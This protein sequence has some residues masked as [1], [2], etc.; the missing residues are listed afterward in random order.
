[1]QAQGKGKDLERQQRQTAITQEL[2]RQLQQWEASSSSRRAEA[3]NVRPRYD[4]GP[5][6]VLKRRSRS[7]SSTKDPF[8]QYDAR[9]LLAT[10]A[11][12]AAQVQ[13]AVNEPAAGSKQEQRGEAATAEATAE[14]QSK[15]APGE[16]E[17]R[18]EDT[19]EEQAAATA[20][21]QHE[22]A[23]AAMF[24]AAFGAPYV[25]L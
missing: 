22:A 17:Q 14:E 6:F 1:M 5:R 2:D 24:Q 3:A 21:R 20:S 18:V 15:A 16:Q 7:D 8:V 12:A 4:R 11:A 25:F 23:A 13:H 19:A 10:V 9:R